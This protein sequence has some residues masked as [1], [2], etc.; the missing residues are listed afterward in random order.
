MTDNVSV[1]PVF[2][3]LC[4]YT[5]NILFHKYLICRFTI[6]RN[7]SLKILQFS[8]Y[9]Y[10]SHNFTFM[11]NSCYYIY[12]LKYVLLIFLNVLIKSRDKNMSCV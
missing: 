8:V 4:V 5:N 12:D 7:Y 3:C 2:P 9:N 11:Y 6:Y 1:A 10:S